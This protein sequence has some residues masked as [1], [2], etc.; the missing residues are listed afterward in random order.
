MVTWKRID[1]G[2]MGWREDDDDDEDCEN[3]GW[4]SLGIPKSKPNIC[5]GYSLS[6][7]SFRFFYSSWR[8]WFDSPGKHGAGGGTRTRTTFYGLRILSPVRLP[9]RHTGYID[10]IEFFECPSPFS[11][12][13]KRNYL[14][15]PSLAMFSLIVTV[16][17]ELVGKHLGLLTSSVP[18][19][20]DNLLDTDAD[21]FGCCGHYMPHTF[22]ANSRA[23]FPSLASTSSMTSPPARTESAPLPRQHQPGLQPSWSS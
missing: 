19:L 9:F 10:S 7:S 16:G 1:F 23:Y 11:P 22:F 3:D 21:V 15:A 17:A 12:P 18:T 4:I 8:A 20:R 6:V 2:G 14:R 5:L 13:G